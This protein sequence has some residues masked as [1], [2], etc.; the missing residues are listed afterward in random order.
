MKSKDEVRQSGEKNDPGQQNNDADG[1]NKRR[2]DGDQPADKH[3]DAPD[4]RPSGGFSK[5]GSRCVCVHVCLLFSTPFQPSPSSDEAT[6]IC[7]QENKP[8]RMLQPPR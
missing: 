3:K 7:S 5:G 8:T 2:R 4:D 1:G 6:A